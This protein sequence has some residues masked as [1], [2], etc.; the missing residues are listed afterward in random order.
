MYKS[1]KHNKWTQNTFVDF[2]KGI[3][4]GCGRCKW[5][6]VHEYQTIYSVKFL[7]PVT[8]RLICDRKQLNL[9]TFIHY[10]YEYQILGNG[11]RT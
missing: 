1:I 10:M 2:I 6:P 9:L 3:A 7:L 11:N 4:R 5:K 8:L